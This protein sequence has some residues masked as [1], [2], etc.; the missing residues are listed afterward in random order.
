MTD[1]TDARGYVFV[2][3]AQGAQD[4][5]VDNV[6][7]GSAS[8]APDGWVPA[9]RATVRTADGAQ[10]AQAGKATNASGFFT[11]PAGGVVTGLQIVIDFSQATTPQWVQSEGTVQGDAPDSLETFTAGFFTAS[12]NLG[13]VSNV[14]RVKSIKSF[15]AELS[16]DNTSGAEATVDLWISSTAGLTIGELFDDQGQPI[17]ADA[18]QA[19]YHATQVTVPP[20]TGQTLNITWA[21]IENQEALQALLNPNEG[22]VDGEKIITLYGTSRPTGNGVTLQEATINLVVDAQLLSDDATIKTEEQI[23]ELDFLSP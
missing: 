13:S 6:V 7:Y 14:D 23:I 8:D 15:T 16:V 1:Q 10:A 5:S 20:G 12:K 22:K 9:V 19:L 18:E 11:T 3:S 2:P 4:L 21:D 17:S